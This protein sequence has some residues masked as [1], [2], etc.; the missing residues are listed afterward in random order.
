[1]TLRRAKT[2]D[3]YAEWVRQALFEAGDLR[4]CLEFEMEDLQRFPAFLAPLQEGIQALHQSMVEGEYLFGREDL[5][6]MDLATRFADQIPF[7]PLL[8]QI[9]ETHRRGLDLDGE[10]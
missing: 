1:M 4:E 7:H 8:R 3:E 2:A 9:N 5:P 10:D 6:F